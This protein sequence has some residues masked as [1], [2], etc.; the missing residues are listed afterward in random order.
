VDNQ[1]FKIIS[2]KMQPK[3]KLVLPSFLADNFI[4]IQHQQLIKKALTNDQ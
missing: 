4:Q 3:E 2:F 1:Q